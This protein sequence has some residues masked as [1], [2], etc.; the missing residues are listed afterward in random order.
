MNV[1]VTGASGYIGSAVA[2][3]LVARGHRVSGLA[4]S[5]EAAAKVRSTGA[6]PVCGALTDLGVLA[7]TAARADG[8]VHTAATTGSDR[9]TC[10]EAAVAA[11]LGKM[12]GGTFV[13]T[14]GA[15]RARSSRV[16]VSEE[17]TAPL[18]GP[19]DWLAAAESRVLDAANV[20]GVVLR[21]PIVYGDGGGP[22]LRLVEQ[23][24]RD[25][26]ARYVAEGA[27]CW[28]TVHVR[29]LA[30]AYALV[31][32]KSATGV[33]HVAEARPER[34]VDIMGAVAAAAHVP[35]QSW[36]LQAALEIH[37]PLAGYLA[38][39]AALDAA[40]LRRELDWRPVVGEMLG[41]LCAAL[42]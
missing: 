30:R 23:A 2:A 12:N 11:M 7:R 25:G 22:M 33:F 3:T 21:P 37:G 24:R 40:R 35:V 16:P 28:S 15:P 39:D 26:V 14:T 29:D 38:M 5:E 18:G 9:A 17:E 34:M 36:T 1:F 10:D 20:R 8:V 31:L 32:E 42:S 19:L 6:T 13:T 27:N 41:G 4:R